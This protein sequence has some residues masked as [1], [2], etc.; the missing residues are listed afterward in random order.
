M[1]VVVSVK[2]MGGRGASRVTRYIAED[3]IIS[4]RE[5]KRR[6]LFS[7]KG[8]DLVGEDRTYREA[9]QYL[10]GGRGAPLKK[11]LIHLVLSFR[12]ED[13]EALGS[14]DLECKGA[15]R[16]IAREAMEETRAELKV[17]DWRW[18]AGIHLNTQ[19][20]H[21][22]IVVHKKVTDRE[23]GHPR[24]LGYLPKRM[25]PHSER[26]SDGVIRPVAG[27]I[28][29][30]FVETLD[31]AQVR[32]QEAERAREEAAMIPPRTEERLT[33][34]EAKEKHQEIAIRAEI[35]RRQNPPLIDRMLESVSSNPSRRGR[36]LTMEIVGRES[37]L[38]SDAQD[39][40]VDDIRIAFR[41]PSIDESDYRTQIEHADWLGQHSQNLRDIYERGAVI[42]GE[43]L[44]IPAEEHEVPG[45][46]DHLR[47]IQISHAHE[48]I[49]NPKTAAEFHYLVRVIAGETADIR[50][51]VEVFQYYHDRSTRDADG[52]RI[53]PYNKD[54]KEQRAR[55]LERTL[56]E[57]RMLAAE[58]V[59]LETRESIDVVPSIAERS[60]IYRY[61]QDYERASEFYSLAQEI[62][63]RDAH[64]PREAQ[65]FSYFY[66]RLERDSEGNRL[67]HENE[68]GRLEAIDRI[69]DEMRQAIELRE[70]A[71]S[72]KYVETDHAHTTFDEAAQ[73]ESAFESEDRQAFAEWPDREI[74]EA[75]EIEGLEYEYTIDDS[76]GEREADAAAWQF[77]AAVR[78]VNLDDERLCIP[79]ELSDRTREWLIEHRLPE[80]DR[81]IERGDSLH[82]VRNENYGIEKHGIIS[83]INRLIE[84]DRDDL[85]RR[86]SKAAGFAGEEALMR[87]A[88]LGEMLAARRT[89]LELCI[90]E[91][92]ELERRRE[93][94][95]RLEASDARER[96]GGRLTEHSDR[97]YIFNHRMAERLGRI[98]DLIAGLE[99][100]VSGFSENQ[101]PAPGHEARLYVSL[102]NAKDALR[103]PVSNIR[104]YDQIERMAGGAKLPLRTRTHREGP[105]LISGLT[106]QEYDYRVKIAGFLKNYV[107]ERLRD[108]ET[109]LTHDYQMF[110]DARQMLDRARTPEE[111]NRVASDFMSRYE[112]Q[113]SPLSERER[114]LLF[115]AGAPDHYTPE[116]IDLRLT[117]G[118]PRDER[119]QALH[120]GTLPPSTTFKAML[121]ELY[122]RRDVES[123]SQFQAAM[124]NPPGEMRNPSRL[125]LYHMYQQ[126]LSHEK[127]QIYLLAE[128]AKRELPSKQPPIR[129][130]SKTSQRTTGR[131]P[132]AIPYG[133]KSYQEYIAAMGEINRQLINEVL[134]QR[135]DGQTLSREEQA[136]LHQRARNL[137]WERLSSVEVFSQQ[138]GEAALKLSD[139]IMKLQ[140]EIQPRAVLATQVLD[141]FSRK[142][143]QSYKDGRVPKG[144]LEKLGPHEREYYEQL[145]DYAQRSREDL[146]RGFEAI[147][148]LRAEIEKARAEE[149]LRDRRALGNAIVTEARY[150]CAKFDYALA[151]DYGHTFR[152]RIHDASTKRTREMSAFDIEQRAI[153]RGAKAANEHSIQRAEERHRI[154]QAVSSTDLDRHSEA[155]SEHHR[156]Q[157]SLIDKCETEAGKAWN[158][159]V[160][161]RENAEIII[162]KYQRRGEL[163]PAPFIDRKIL[164]KMQEETIKRGIIGQT[165]TLEQIR[166]AQ[167]QEFN[168]PARTVAETARLRGQLFVARTDLQ[169]RED[170]AEKFDRT[171][172]L[173]QWEIGGG[174]F[175]LADV[176]RLLEQAIDRTRIL[177]KSE[178][179]LF[180]RKQAD[181][182]AERLTAIRGAI[183]GLI[184]E[185]RNELHNRVNET[186]K[187]V[188]MLSQTYERETAYRGQTRQAM[189]EPRFTANE[190]DRISD[191]AATLRNVSLLRHFNEFERRFNNYADPKDHISLDARLAHARGREVMAE[192]FL[193]ES[194]TRQINLRDTKEV[195]PLL[196]EM[197]DGRLITHRF[198]DTQPQSILEAIVRPHIETPAD[199]MLREA[200][201]KSLQNQQQYLQAEAEKNRSY[202]EVARGITRALT[203]ER[204]NGM[205]MPLPA[206]EFSP[207]ELALI[208]RYASRLPDGKERDHYLAFVKSDRSMTITHQPDHD[209][210]NRRIEKMAFAPE[211]HSIEM[212]RGR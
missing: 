107:Y 77:N 25:L 115:N 127:D 71:D 124:I 148:G 123:V 83:D 88:S 167:S 2:S 52:H 194:V 103:L 128:K 206:P 31:R 24:N 142:H 41:S 196:V 153:A 118:L 15:L 53:D 114:K 61:I 49:A 209:H 121:G 10:S 212:G 82:D 205:D 54:Y 93:L 149:L 116:M 172:H 16:E 158:A 30:H 104:V 200:V 109:R 4:D 34:E 174:K 50:T 211:P 18:V 120:T 131:S 6:P 75:Q 79:E 139:T 155:L 12:E 45:E 166:I 9:N 67:A 157:K 144:A 21:L 99:E 207:K 80:L 130:E 69:L 48:K 187:L 190:L 184:A 134:S 105:A 74:D 195:Q 100:R 125:P 140:E 137:A 198:K 44:I 14:N 91:K 189:P 63:G 33:P 46:R 126:L 51:E 132:G 165:E 135:G 119:R 26:G 65:I 70:A 86:V 13:F 73:P 210:S 89:L 188:E 152:F 173:R 32:A 56:A 97:S 92:S 170:R 81:R 110:R 160:A 108:P 156:I 23:N 57:M 106:E 22:H 168:R 197:P 175:S 138:L 102:S 1:R 37:R 94:R 11:E 76:Y 28:G 183:V 8:D 191:N 117:W 180:G 193:H 36:D 96:I 151:R 39:N 133:S 111:L 27:V 202:Y 177:G 143:I 78:K 171:L 58:M 182:E 60:H 145:T 62:A 113:A 147:D 29:K 3:G 146:Y 40:P 178:I 203:A 186:G 112:R 199:S 150:E 136:G 42:K 208:E 129:T 192:I 181:N 169:V 7:E 185:Q 176:D 38:G 19:Q 164:S 66:G 162:D 159:S 122:R 55:A 179:H 84:P 47:V 87:P 204:N 35:S 90:Y 68:A 161:A 154:R 64:L 20:P 95:S 59:Q 17:A 163:S 43:T 5:G 101:E 85:L 141:E 98:E 201:Q 72:T